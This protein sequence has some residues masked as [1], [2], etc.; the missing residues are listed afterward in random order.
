M[1]RILLTTLVVAGSVGMSGVVTATQTPSATDVAASLQQ[2]YDGVRDFSADFVHEAASG[3]LR[4][5]LVE[6]GTLLVKKP[7]KMRWTYKEPEQKVF[8]SD[9]IRMYMHTPADNQVIVS[10][11]P[12]EDQA[13]TAVLFLTGKGRLTRD[14]IVSFAEGGGPDTYALRLQPKLPE[15]DYDW[16]QLVVDRKTLQIRSLAASDKQGTHSTFTFSNFKENVGL[17]DKAFTFTIPRGADV[18]QAGPSGR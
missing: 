6:R 17:T 16:L 5:K 13:T 4:K 8:V 12:G 15:R 10:A 2:K 7:G 9:G 14:F 3:V 11:V 1:M 18:I